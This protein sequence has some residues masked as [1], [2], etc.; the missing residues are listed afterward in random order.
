LLENT[1][2][3]ESLTSL[4]HIFAEFDSLSS[5]VHEYQDLFIASEVA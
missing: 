5:R 4:Y 3:F 2:V 1:L